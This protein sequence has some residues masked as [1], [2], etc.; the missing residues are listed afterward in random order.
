MTHKR[1]HASEVSSLFYIQNKNETMHNHTR[2]IPSRVLTTTHLTHMSS[3]T[4]TWTYLFGTIRRDKQKK[5]I[6]QHSRLAKGHIQQCTQTTNFFRRAADS[7][8]LDDYML[9]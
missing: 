6:T 1:L 4:C 8:C 9:H 3:C 7:I 2:R 5:Q